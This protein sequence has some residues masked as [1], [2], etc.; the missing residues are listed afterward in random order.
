VASDGTA[1]VLG[2]TGG[3][4]GEVAQLFVAKRLFAALHESA[5]GT[6]R[7]LAVPSLCQ[8]IGISGRG[9]KISYENACRAGAR[10]AMKSS[11]DGAPPSPFDVTQELAVGGF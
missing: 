8:L 10:F 1:L 6:K 4:G 2:A 7:R 5:C 11:A 3:I 9:G